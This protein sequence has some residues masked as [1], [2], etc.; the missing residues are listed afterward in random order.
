MTDLNDLKKN[1]FFEL[2]NLSGR[3]YIVVR[4]SPD[5]DLGK[6]V[7]TEDEK[8]NGLTLVFTTR[9]PV[10]WNAAGIATTLSFGAQAYRCFIPSQDILAIY[11]PD[12]HVQ[13]TCA[14]EDTAT[15]TEKPSRGQTAPKQSPMRKKQGKVIEVDFAKRL[16]RE[17]DE[18]DKEDA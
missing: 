2:L 3:V 7:F 9:M 1:V 15:V 4:Y 11:S 18:S 13:L 5:V 14:P 8:L 17:A 12:L 16:R 6:K 10:Q